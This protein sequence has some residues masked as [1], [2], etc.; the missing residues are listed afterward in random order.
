MD[1]LTSYFLMFI[2]YAFL[3]YI[4]EVIYVFLIT[5]KITNRG[6]L[7]GPLVPIYAFGALFIII[8]LNEFSFG[9][10]ITDRWYLVVLIGILIPSLLEYITS[11]VME[12]LFKMRWWD[13]SDKFLNINGR[14]CLR[15]S[16][17]FMALVLIVVYLLNPTFTK[18]VSYIVEIDVLNYILCSILFI[19]LCVDITLSTIHH[20][21]ISKIIYKLDELKEK[22]IIYKDDKMESLSTKIDNAKAKTSN[23]INEI[24]IKLEKISERYPSLKLII[25]KKKISFKE[26]ISKFKKER[27][28]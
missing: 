28:E 10:F 3:G 7:Y 15:N 23:Y 8:P 17:M 1:K 20:I 11:F 6:Y 14:I 24:K 19:A 13:Y 22:A 9:T 12:K 25:N 4:C 5:K 18:L 16:L 2:I 21:N 27:E 26:Y